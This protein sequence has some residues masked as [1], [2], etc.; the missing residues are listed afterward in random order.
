[1]EC[2]SPSDHWLH[3]ISCSSNR[4]RTI[5]LLLNSCI[6]SKRAYQNHHTASNTQTFSV[7]CRGFGTRSEQTPHYLS[8]NRNSFLMCVPSFT[9][10]SCQAL[11]LSEVLDPD[12]ASKFSIGEM[13]KTQ[14]RK[15]RQN[16]PLQT[17]LPRCW[18]VIQNPFSWM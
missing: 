11:K 6:I 14:T 12:T 1:M 15:N 8:Q 3:F 2:W 18:S 10:I 7:S 13:A 5:L 4:I 17:F 16:K 9:S